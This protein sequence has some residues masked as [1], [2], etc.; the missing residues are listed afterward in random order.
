MRSLPVNM[1][2]GQ[3]AFENDEFSVRMSDKNPFG[4]NETDKTIDNTINRDCKR[5]ED[6]LDLVPILLSHKDGC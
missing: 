4:R 2:E 1:P 6:I 3:K 5:E